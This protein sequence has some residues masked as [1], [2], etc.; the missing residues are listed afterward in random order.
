MAMSI[1]YEDQDPVGLL[2]T[3]RN[4]QFVAAFRDLGRDLNGERFT[5]DIGPVDWHGN[6]S[7][8][9]FQV[10][11]ST[12]IAVTGH[13]FDPDTKPDLSSLFGHGGRGD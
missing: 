5:V 10:T 8:L 9:T 4:R 6:E 1:K 2:D 3:E 13:T 12:R 7:E 11:T